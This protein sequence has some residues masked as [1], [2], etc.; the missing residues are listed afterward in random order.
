M[1]F[2]RLPN[3]QLRQGAVP[4]LVVDPTLAKYRSQLTAS[5]TEVFGEAS[6]LLDTTEFEDEDA[7]YHVLFE[8]VEL[9]NESID[10][11]KQPQK[12]IF[13]LSSTTYAIVLHICGGKTY[14]TFSLTYA[15]T[16]RMKMPG[17]STA[18][19]LRVED[20]VTATLA[21]LSCEV[22][23]K[24]TTPSDAFVRD[25]LAHGKPTPYDD[26]VLLFD[27]VL[28]Q[29]DIMDEKSAHIHWLY[30]F[31][32][33][34]GGGRKA[35][36]LITSLADKHC[37][38]L[39]LQV[40]PFQFSSPFSRRMD[41]TDPKRIPFDKLTRFYESFG[42]ELWGKDHMA[43]DPSCQT[44][45]QRAATV[46]WNPRRFARGWHIPEKLLTKWNVDVTNIFNYV[47][48]STNQKVKKFC[49]HPMSGELLIG[50]TS[51][52]H[53]T[54][55][56]KYGSYP[57]DDY[58]IATI[59]DDLVLIHFWSPDADQNNVASFEA[60]YAFSKE[61]LPPVTNYKI[62]VQESDGMY[63]EAAMTTTLPTLPRVPFS[64][65]ANPSWWL[66]TTDGLG[67]VDPSS[68]IEVGEVLNAFDDLLKV[69]CSSGNW[70][71]EPYMHGMAN[72]MILMRSVVSGEDAKFL[73]APDHWLKDLPNHLEVGREAANHYKAG[74]R[75]G[76]ALT[77]DLVHVAQQLATIPPLLQVNGTLFKRQAR[78]TTAGWRGYYE[79]KKNNHD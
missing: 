24:S 37:V 30:S 18:K 55:T 47:E 35:F 13:S 48:K 9:L 33:K 41:M 39:T 62:R 10:A 56:T 28:A 45:L 71:Y 12:P 61:V 20:L 46:R 32:Q 69:Q 27:N 72:G 77:K 58:I 1:L 4:A 23:H 22:G 57:H 70:N 75:K 19:P 54:L 79:P 26:E 11:I 38:N 25:L 43:R 59:S 64:R 49:W 7:V 3:K 60:Q 14:K 63:K 73:E 67:K 78:V 31:Q 68:K 50:A 66:S 52:H 8:L 40:G 65:R 16:W 15:G 6:K 36:E 5:F 34:S 76:I 2:F 74:F 51:V 17:S 53:S 29:F 21:S 44:N 42:F